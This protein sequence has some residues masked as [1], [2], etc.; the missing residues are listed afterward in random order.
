MIKI[1]TIIAL[2][3]HKHWPL[4]QLDVNNTFL[5]GDLHEKVYMKH[6]EGLI[7]LTYLPTALPKPFLQVF[8]NHYYPFQTWIA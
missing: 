3:S 2:A 4:Y 1:R 7:H 8:P 6:P 5:H